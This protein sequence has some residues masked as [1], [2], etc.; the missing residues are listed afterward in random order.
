VSVPQ[1]KDSTL[2]LFEFPHLSGV[3][4]RLQYIE[5]PEIRMFNIYGE[6][7]REERSKYEV[8]AKVVH[9]KKLEPSQTLKIEAEV[10]Q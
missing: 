4:H 6:G 10:F 3:R 7:K 2:C 9:A 5:V 8:K 1:A